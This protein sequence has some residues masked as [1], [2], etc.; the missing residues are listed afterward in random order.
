LFSGTGADML[1]D[2]AALEQAGARHT[3]LYLQRSTIEETLDVMQR[4][5]EEVIRKA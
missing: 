2:A 3:I 4:F 1:A 5:A